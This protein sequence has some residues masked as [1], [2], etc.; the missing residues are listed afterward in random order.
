MNSIKSP[1]KLIFILSFDTDNESTRAFRKTQIKKIFF[2][3]D[4]EDKSLE[5]FEEAISLAKN[6]NAKLRIYHKIPNP[7]EPLVASGAYLL[8]GSWVPVSTYFD[9][10]TEIREEK[11][12]DWINH[13]KKLLSF[14]TVA[15]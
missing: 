4:L 3:T 6:L 12:Q 10:T 7:V 9:K 13:A 5:V 2:P 11:A 14:S 8:G 1:D 15:F